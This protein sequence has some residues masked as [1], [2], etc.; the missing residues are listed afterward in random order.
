MLATRMA[1]T[2]TRVSSAPEGV[3]PAADDG[4]LVLAKQPLDPLERDGIHVPRVARD[5]SHPLHAA[6]VGSVKTVIHAR[7]QPQRREQPAAVVAHQLIV[8]QQ[9]RQ[10]IRK[11][12]RLQHGSVLHLT[13][14]AHQRVAGTR[15]DAPVRRRGPR[16]VLELAGKAGVQALES[17]AP[18]IAQIEVRKHPP[19]GN[20][21]TRTPRD[22]RCGSTNPRIG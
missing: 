13:A 17:S 7:G 15:Q 14:C 19:Q 1:A 11:A 8:V 21:R 6:V 20:C 10:R 9:I 4:A 18:G 16:T 3:Q 5:V 2:G 22:A 12:L